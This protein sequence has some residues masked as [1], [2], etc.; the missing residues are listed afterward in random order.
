MFPAVSIYFL[1]VLLIFWVYCGYIWF[2][3][4]FYVLHPSNVLESGKPGILPKI[5]VLIP[6]YNEENYV[7][8]KVENTRA[9]HYPDEL[10]EVYFLN[11]LSTDGTSPMLKEYT[12]GLSNWHVIDTMISGKILQL[13]KGLSLLPPDI[14]IVV[15]T[16]MD[17]ILNDDVLEKIGIQFATD[18][19]IVVVGANISPYNG[20]PI[21]RNYWENQN[22]IRILESTVYASSIVVAPCYAFRRTLLD[23]FPADCV[24]DDIYV[25]FRANT[26]GGL[27]CYLAD[28]KGLELRNPNTIETFFSH[29]FRKGNAFMQEILRFVYMLPAMNIWW[30]VIYLTKL[31]Q[32]AVI[33]W[34]LPY[35]ALSTLSFLLDGAGLFKLAVLGC[36]FLF[37]AV[38]VS[39]YSINRFK[40][41]HFNG[42]Q[43][44]NRKI[45]LPF[46]I[47]N[48]ILIL[49]GLSYPFYQQS[50][51]YKKVSL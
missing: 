37:C 13:N 18:Q 22:T 32:V 35:F 43:K 1:M 15:N 16:D 25:A 41:I 21:E 9:L 47:S 10:L 28:A 8:R 11:G 29:K 19:R 17:T 7:T 42:A 46:L 27:T 3:F 14:D 48:L 33:P 50:S 36:S 39:S 26:A 24:A 31:L 49:V 44:K 23:A 5:A 45:M 4:M 30:K 40:K 6:C 34:I 2:L 51:N 12:A 20:I 38:I